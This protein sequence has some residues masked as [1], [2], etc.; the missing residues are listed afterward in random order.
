[1]ASDFPG[2]KLAHWICSEQV[3]LPCPSWQFTRGNGYLKCEG[4]THRNITAK[5]SW[6]CFSEFLCAMLS[7]WLSW[8]SKLRAPQGLV[9]T[10]YEGKDNLNHNTGEQNIS[11]KKPVYQEFSQPS[12]SKKYR[13][14]IHQTCTLASGLTIC[15]KTMLVS[16]AILHLEYT[17]KNEMV[18]QAWKSHLYSKASK[19]ISK[20][21]YW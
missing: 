14:W 11:K 7:T 6:T 16:H 4:S 18:F 2:M 17:I 5:K 13:F 12:S 19:M 9:T 21:H 3:T 20:L 10:C 1:M 8:N 15:Q